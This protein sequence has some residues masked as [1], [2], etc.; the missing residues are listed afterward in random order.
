MYVLSVKQLFILHTNFLLIYVCIYILTLIS[1]NL[2]VNFQ[3]NFENTATSIVTVV[4][5]Y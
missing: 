5:R 4:L 2:Y 1:S 3:I